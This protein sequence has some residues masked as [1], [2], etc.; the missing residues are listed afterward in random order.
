MRE[1]LTQS[2]KLEMLDEVGFGEEDGPA[3][4]NSGVEDSQ[5]V[6]TNASI[7]S[8]NAPEFKPFDEVMKPPPFVQG[9]GIA[10]TAHNPAVTFWNPWNAG[11]RNARYTLDPKGFGLLFADTFKGIVRF[12]KNT[13]TDTLAGYWSVYNGK[14]WVQGDRYAVLHKYT[15]IFFSDFVARLPAP[16]WFAKSPQFAANASKVTDTPESVWRTK[17]VGKY[18][19]ERAQREALNNAKSEPFIVA[20][21]EMFDNA[22]NTGHLLNVK[23][24]VI[25]LNTMTL[26]PH[27]PKYLVAKYIDVPWLQEAHNRAYCPIVDE[28]LESLM[29]A[30]ITPYDPKDEQ[31]EPPEFR[32]SPELLRF[33]KQ[34]YGYALHGKKWAKVLFVDHGNLT[35]N[36]KSTL[37]QAFACMMGLGTGYGYAMTA[38]A[39]LILAPAFNNQNGPTEEWARLQ[40]ARFVNVSE[41]PKGVKLN[42]S[43]LKEAADNK[44]INARMLRQNSVTFTAQ[45]VINIQVNDLPA[46]DDETIFSRGTILVIPW[47]RCFPP[48]IESRDN[49]LDQKLR[50]QRAKERILALAIEGLKDLN[51]Q[52]NRAFAIPEE[53][54]N[55]TRKYAETQDLITRFIAECLEANTDAEANPVKFKIVWDRYREWLY[56]E[57]GI[58]RKARRAELVE[59]LRRRKIMIERDSRTNADTLIGYTVI[60]SEATREAIA[61]E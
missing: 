34:K 37:N 6:N 49:Q 42:S 7:I 45:Y 58:T 41:P 28:T 61:A 31:A 46:V 2:Q 19:T 12:V 26:M 53:V 1:S 40:G 33:V 55:A 9:M 57:Q 21:P 44:E 24:G 60:E 36:G 10:A 8:Q 23:N 5:C 15:K 14:F 48:H 22:D 38:R 17:I 30:Y 18:K 35:N 47:N 59:G 32:H 25:D 39:S 56:E 27:S 43:E 11:G 52:L 3:G 50:T 29:G 51:E 13:E 4:G 20:T 16:K 54:K